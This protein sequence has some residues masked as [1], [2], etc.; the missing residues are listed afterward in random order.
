M[1]GSAL[2]AGLPLGL[3]PPEHLDLE[4]GEH[5]HVRVR[6]RSSADYHDLRG[7]NFPTCSSISAVQMQ[8]LPTRPRPIGTDHRACPAG[9]DKVRIVLGPISAGKT[10]W[11]AEAVVHSPLLVTYLDV[12]DMPARRWQRPLHA[13]VAGKMFGRSSGKLGR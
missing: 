4:A 2:A 5:G 10:A 8:E 6:S 13:R 1:L 9:D 12:I 3:L 11:V 7:R